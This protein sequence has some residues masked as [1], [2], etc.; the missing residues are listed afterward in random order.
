[1]HDTQNKR[2]NE[3]SRDW[4]Y[5]TVIDFDEVDMRI[6]LPRKVII[7]RNRLSSCLPNLKPLTVLLYYFSTKNENFLL[8]LL[9]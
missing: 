1:M 2:P 7:H 4:I 3:M 6:Y 9:L 8:S 5:Y